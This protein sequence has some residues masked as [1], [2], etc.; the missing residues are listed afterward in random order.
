MRTQ[1]GAKAARKTIRRAE[2]RDGDAERPKD[3]AAAHKPYR[4]A[5]CILVASVRMSG[6]MD[7]PRVERA[8]RTMA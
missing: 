3:A 4:C 8:S 2:Q 1:T 6:S 7:F 5:L